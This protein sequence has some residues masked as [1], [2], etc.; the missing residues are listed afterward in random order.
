[1]SESKS[2]LVTHEIVDIW[3]RIQA[4]DQVFKIRTVQSK[5]VLRE[6]LTLSAASL[7][8]TQGLFI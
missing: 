4:F 5:L 2:F 7:F 8:V 1:M 6:R 3:A